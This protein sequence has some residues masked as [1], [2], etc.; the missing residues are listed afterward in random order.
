MLTSLVSCVEPWY[1]C[2]RT[3]AEPLTRSYLLLH[4]QVLHNGDPLAILV[5]NSWVAG[6]VQQDHSGWYLLTSSRVGI[7]LSAG[8]TARF[9]REEEKEAREP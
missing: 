9:E 3:Q 4:G 5:I 1:P 8:L 6:E 7:R 2:E